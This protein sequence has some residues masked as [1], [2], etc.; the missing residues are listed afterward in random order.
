MRFAI[1]NCNSYIFRLKN[2]QTE[3]RAKP[4]KPGKQGKKTMRSKLYPSEY[5]ALLTIK[6]EVDSDKFFKALISAEKNRK[7]KCGDLSI[8]CRKKQNREVIFLITQGSKVVA[9]LKI[10]EDLLTKKKNPIKEVRNNYLNDKQNTKRN[11]KSQ[12]LQ[13]KDLQIGMKKI[14][15]QARIIEISKPKYVITRFGNHARVANAT[16]SDN[17]GKIKLCLWNDQIDTVTKGNTIQIQ[18]AKISTFKNEKQ[19]RIGKNGTLQTTKTPSN[20]QSL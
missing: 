19:L 11:S 18:N 2:P 8:E 20:K 6:Y 17:T 3:K 5:L 10:P 14:N 7:S 15:L 13:I 1:V 4:N 16:I 9:Q 12:T